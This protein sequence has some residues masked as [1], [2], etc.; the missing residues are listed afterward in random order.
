MSDVATDC[1]HRE[2]LGWLEESHLMGNSI[3]YNYDILRFYSKIIADMRDAQLPNGLVPDIAPEYVVFSGG[4]RDSPEWGSAC[5]L[6][7]WYVYKWY[8]D[9]EALRE[10][11]SMMKRYVNYLNGKAHHHLLAYGLGDWFDLGPRGPGVS[12]LTPLGVTATAFYY[13]DAKVVGKIG[14]ILGDMSAA[15]HYALLADTV[16]QAF[17]TKY[18]DAT[19]GVYATG[20]QTSNAIPLYFGL[21]PERYR[22]KILNNLVDS[23]ISNK[24]ALTA[25][26]IGFRYLIEA[27]EEGGFSQVIFK[28]NNRKDVPGYGYQISKGATSLTESWR[29][30]RSVSNDH[31][32]LGHLMEWFYSGLGG[33]GQQQDGAG[34]N[35][36]RIAPQFVDGITWVNTTYNSIHGPIAVKWN[37]EG[38]H[39]MH[40]QVNIPA[41]TRAK[42]ILPVTRPERIREGR[43]NAGGVAPNNK[44]RIIHENGSCLMETGSGKYDFYFPLDS[45]GTSSNQL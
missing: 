1:P 6:V 29:A 28:M 37:R 42:I 36:I 33:I 32:M 18:F 14:A 7:P 40:L 15:N 8:G 31:M 34:Y 10:N 27:L 12:Q 11:Y 45:P 24:Y 35:K 21:A 3:Q 30:L 44:I 23:I 41:N 13:Y 43:S 5:V 9:R 26:D 16:R 2:K 19:H 22:R 25:G 17:N 39:G 38:N 4:F 20:S